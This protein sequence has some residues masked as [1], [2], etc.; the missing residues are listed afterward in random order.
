[1]PLKK[2]HLS[3]KHNFTFVTVLLVSYD[4]IRQPQC[5]LKLIQITVIMMSN[6]NN[7][8]AQRSIQ[9]KHELNGAKRNIISSYIRVKPN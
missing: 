6:Y 8:V 3:K 9:F 5:N 1:M 7:I 4:V 2:R